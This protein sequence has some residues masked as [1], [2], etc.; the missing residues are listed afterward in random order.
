[1]E[2]EEANGL[3]GSLG[4]TVVLDVDDAKVHPTLAVRHIA[5]SLCRPKRAKRAT[6]DKKK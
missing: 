3:G 2:R 5:K 4:E 1:M 6:N